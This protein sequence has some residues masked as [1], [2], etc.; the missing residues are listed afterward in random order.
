VVN[1]KTEDIISVP[2]YQLKWNIVKTGIAFFICTIINCTVFAQN[3]LPAIGY[4]RLHLN[5]KNT[6]QVIKGDK[7]Y[8]ATSNNLFSI[9]KSNTAEL[10]TKITGLNDFGVSCIGWDETTKQ[11]IIIYNNSNIDVLKSSSVTNIGDVLRSTI[12]GNKTVSNVFCNNGLAYL[13]SGLGIIVTDLSKYEIKDTWIIGNT[14]NQVQ[15][16]GFTTDGTYYYAATSEGVKQCK[17]NVGNPADFHNWT[18]LYGSNGLNSGTANNIIYVNNLII[19]QKA[20]SLFTLLNNKWNLLYADTSWQVLNINASNNKIM[21][22]QQAANGNSRVVQLNTNGTIEKNISKAG[23]VSMPL[24]AIND[25]TSIWVADF[26]GGLSNFGTTVQQY[27]PNGPPGVASGEMAYHKDTLLVA[28]GG[29]EASWN[30]TYNRNG[31]YNFSNDLWDYEGYYNRPVLDSVLDFITVVSDPNDG[32]YWGG[33]YGGG[34]VHFTGTQ[35]T[36]FKQNYIQPAIGDPS[37]YRV[38]GLCFDQNNNLW[39]SNYGAPQDLKVRK[40]DG[41]WKSFTIPF[42]H[43]ENALSQLVVDDANQIWMVSP[44]GNGVFC[45]N[46]NGTI[47]NTADDQWKKLQTGIGQGNLPSNN[48]YCLANDK[49]GFI[50]I[51]T[52]NGIAVM[53]C[54]TNIFQQSCDAILP[55][56]QQGLIAGYLF[57]NQTVQCIAVDGADR[58]WVGTTNGVWLVSE[59]GTSILYHFTTDNSPLPNNNVNHIAIDPKTG[60]VFFSTFSGICSFRSTATESSSANNTVLVFPNPVP[61]NFNGTIGIRG[62]ADNADVKITELNGRLVYETISLGGQAIW[63]GYNYKG[64]KV[65]SGIYL[66]FVKDPNGA[67]NLVTKIVI[68][69]GR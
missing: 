16:N 45:L 57:Q 29:V 64:Q 8:C 41:S 36:I 1:I 35:T 25:S 19:S 55:V 61:P 65:A 58:K 62:L 4:W 54:A 7:I 40:A 27:I 2:T 9:N 34:L 48:V 68:I 63:N 15:V 53:Q 69:S 49:N 17:M 28:A 18:N 12:S 5:Y 50:W 26:Y 47:D 60:E 14:G 11:L 59:D 22:C 67:E 20:D 52:D 32:S 66:L 51:G 56:V 46:N 31:I 3:P 30:Y 39:I 33:S 44:K 38:S 42:A 21:V 6:V 23:V 10:Y 37:G 43:T 24:N 13:C